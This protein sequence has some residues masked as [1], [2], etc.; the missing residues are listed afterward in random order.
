MKTFIIILLVC[1]LNGK[2]NHNIEG[3]R[4]EDNSSETLK[5]QDY[6]N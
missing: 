5:T 3:G 4:K 1:T 6:D 2:T